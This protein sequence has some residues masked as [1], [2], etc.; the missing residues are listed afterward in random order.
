MVGL[1]KW[2]WQPGYVVETHQSNF[3]CWSQTF[4]GNFAELVPQ[5]SSLSYD[6]VVGSQGLDKGLGQI[7]MAVV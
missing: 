2:R 1:G 3:L 7:A 6:V 4:N 5:Q